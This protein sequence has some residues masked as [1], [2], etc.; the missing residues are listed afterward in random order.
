MASEIKV[1]TISENTSANGITIDGVKVKDSGI[2]SFNLKDYSNDELN[3]ANEILHDKNFYKVWD[4]F[5]PFDKEY[6]AEIKNNSEENLNYLTRM[7]YLE[8]SN[9][10]K[11]YFDNIQT[12]LKILLQMLCRKVLKRI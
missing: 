11:T 6:N 9:L 3:L 2:E 12:I 8:S 4:N 1:D 10:K 7:E 5:N